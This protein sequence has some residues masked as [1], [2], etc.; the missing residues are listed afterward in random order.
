M[1]P[2]NPSLQVSGNPMKKEAE[3]IEGPE[4]MEDTKKT[5]PSKSI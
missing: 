5:R 1:P 2:L 3:R 4:G